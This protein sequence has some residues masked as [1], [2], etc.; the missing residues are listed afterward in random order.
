[1]MNR[2]RFDEYAENYKEIVSKATK[3]SGECYEYFAE[4][5]LSLMRQELAART[6]RA[7]GFSLH[8]FGCGGGDTAKIMP[9]IF[10]ESII[11]G[12]D[13]SGESIA[14]ATALNLP[15]ATFVKIEN[16]G[17]PVAD[18]TFDATYSNGTFH[19]IDWNLHETFMDEIRRATKPG[20]H[21]VICENNP[22]N[23]FMLHAM[24]VNPF[25]DGLKAVPPAR[26]IRAGKVA[27]L[28]YLGVRYYFFFP[29]IL[30]FMRPLESFLGNIPFGAQYYVLFNK[31]AE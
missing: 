27:G 24:K 12:T 28:N 7:D 15:N 9:T 8:D 23:P 10:P 1:M 29:N 5:R 2:P 31:S 26:L 18:N 3:L 21:R 25:D 17:L 30:K 16:T 4:L 19:H 13:E 11:T 6:G 14:K 20:G 22:R